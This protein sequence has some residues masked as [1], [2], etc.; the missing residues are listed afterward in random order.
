[1]SAAY[2]IHAT[3]NWRRGQVHISWMTSTHHVPEKAEY[4]IESA[5][6]SARS[7][8]GDKLFDGPMCRLET[9][10]ANPWQLRLIMSRTSYRPF[11]GTNLM[12][13]QLA[14]EFGA[15]VLANPIGVSTAL[16]TSDGFILMGRRNDSVAYYPNRVHPFAG[17]L[18]PRDDLDVFD[19][20][21]REMHEELAMTPDSIADIACL[22][23][24]EDNTIRHPELIF[25]LRSELTRQ[26]IEAKLD[27]T[28]HV[29]TYAIQTSDIAKAANDP[30]LTPIA[31][32]ALDLWSQHRFT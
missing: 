15:N 12:N 25:H 23:V 19:D 1:M 6:S 17:A 26:Q 14:D 29:G 24:V 9:F 16:E 10:M 28:E 30:Q 13:P 18:E 11:L 5:W 8:L 21:C 27:P 20:V 3:G 4:A 2:T 7:R 31:L 22:G 32:A